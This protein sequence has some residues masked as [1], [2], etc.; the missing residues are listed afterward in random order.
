MSV[1]MFIV[2]ALALIAGIGMIGWGIPINEFS[3]G[4]TL[5]MSGTTAVVGGLI[6]IGLGAVVSHLKI[7]AEAVSAQGLVAPSPVPDALESSLAQRGM[8]AGA[9][10]P[11]PPRPK[12][13]VGAPLAE[14]SAPS[15][16][17]AR[18]AGAPPDD[19]PAP[20]LRNPDVPVMPPPPADRVPA[21]PHIGA[22][23][24]GE[25]VDQ[26]KPAVP[27]LRRDAARPG[28]FDTM[29][30]SEPTVPKSSLRAE[31]K[32]EPKAE[33]AAEIKPERSARAE[34]T[35]PPAAPAVST[36]PHQEDG[37]L[38]AVA[39]LKSGVVDGMGYTLYVDGSIEAE[40][41][42]GTLRFASIT[43]LRGYL[44]KNG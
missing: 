2:G 30:P 5:I 22:P 9:R 28:S 26:A 37:E 40:L 41:P 42:Q 12:P 39:I 27:P 11:F 3:F 1:A 25:S 36:P 17:A 29:W 32:A 44:G 33:P 16:A 10:L 4:N 19:L 38:R 43:E 18:P 7:L 34:P 31:P 23:R 21:R 24:F 35:S 6:I 14:P 15:S 8:T 20:R 13:D